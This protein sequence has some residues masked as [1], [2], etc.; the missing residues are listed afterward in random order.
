MNKRRE[1]VSEIGYWSE[2][3]LDIPFHTKGGCQLDG[4]VLREFP[5]SV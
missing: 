4:R 5:A 2:V 3:K 1:D